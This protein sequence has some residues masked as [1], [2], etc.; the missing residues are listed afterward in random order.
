MK[1]I[2]IISG[3]TLTATESTI[4]AYKREVYEAETTRRLIAWL[5]T[6]DLSE[7]NYSDIY[8]DIYGFRPRW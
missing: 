3:V 6:H 2:T 7:E 4:R 1:T 5:K 8:K